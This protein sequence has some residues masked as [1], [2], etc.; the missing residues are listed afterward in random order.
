MEN[1]EGRQ[2]PL[3]KEELQQGWSTIITPLCKFWAELVSPMLMMKAQLWL[4][5]RWLRE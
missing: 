1:L 4:G 2:V 3:P 5:Q